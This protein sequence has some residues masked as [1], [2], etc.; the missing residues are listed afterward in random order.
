[1]E[2]ETISNLKLGYLHYSMDETCPASTFSSPV[3]CEEHNN[4]NC[5][6]HLGIHLLKQL[7]LIS[8]SIVAIATGEWGGDSGE[9]GL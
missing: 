9:R 3:I 5:L 2:V 7:P 1:M 6:D 8:M 4:L